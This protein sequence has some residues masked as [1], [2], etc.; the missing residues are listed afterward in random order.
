MKPRWGGGRGGEVNEIACARKRI[1]IESGGTR[2]FA[3]IACA[4]PPSTPISQ[5]TSLPSPLRT[6]TQVATLRANMVE[7]K[8]VQDLLCRERDELRYKARTAVGYKARAVIKGRE[9][10]VCGFGNDEDQ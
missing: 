10:L 3:R 7:S 8:R 4:P 2:A 6:H 5:H 9:V 1:S